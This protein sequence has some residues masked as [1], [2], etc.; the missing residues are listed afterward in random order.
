MF[1]FDIAFRSSE[2]PIEYS[3]ADF[4]TQNDINCKEGYQ[5]LIQD[6]I[7]RQRLLQD[8]PWHYDLTPVLGKFDPGISKDP[9]ALVDHLRQ[10]DLASEA[11]VPS[12]IEF[13]AR[14]ELALDLALSTDIFSPRPCVH[15]VKDD[16]D[17]L[18]TM[19]R[20]TEAMS[21][22]D[23]PPPVHLTY[24]RPKLEGT[25]NSRPRPRSQTVSPASQDLESPLGVR[26]LLKEW[27]VGADL[28]EYTY[29]D[30]YD[31]SYQD[32]TPIRRS[33]NIESSV[34]ATQTTM[35]TQSQRPPLVIASKS[36]V[37]PTVP[38]PDIPTLDRPGAQFQG[39]MNRAPMVRTASQTTAKDPDVG[40]SSQ[41]FMTSTQILPGPFGGRQLIKKKPA[42]KRL[43]GF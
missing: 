35:P 31:E 33:R 5:A 41:D 13:E 21:L 11:A 30:P 42:K 38:V 7:P 32:S 39:L 26:L 36:L 2:K 43:G 23:E 15:P 4:L 34:Q 25:T 19:S 28:H 37:P 27:D 22:V 16:L 8:A 10:Y 18:E 40:A 12:Q 20:A 29:E 9:Q 24:L 1:R 3:R 17:V 14:E 6:R